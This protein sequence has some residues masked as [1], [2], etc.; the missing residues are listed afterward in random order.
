MKHFYSRWKI[1]CIHIQYKP[2]I[3]HLTSIFVHLNFLDILLF[4]FKYSWIN[5][6]FKDLIYYS[7][8]NR[9]KSFFI[10]E[11]WK[12]FANIWIIYTK[13]FSYI[14]RC[15]YYD[16]FENVHI[17]FISFN[18]RLIV[19]DLIRVSSYTQEHPR[20]HLTPDKSRKG[21]PSRIA[22]QLPD[23]AKITQIPRPDTTPID[24]PPQK[25]LEHFSDMRD[26]DQKS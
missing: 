11:Y 18:W 23:P 8:E 15:W 26:I 5:T 21:P 20:G 9:D 19:D 2:T 7:S 12:Y 14:K 3:I 25:V 22:I 10:F 6:K 24:K 17:S 4:I 13:Y 16:I 1:R